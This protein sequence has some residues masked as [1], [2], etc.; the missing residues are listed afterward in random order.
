M[1]Q[2][3]PIR[4]LHLTRLFEAV[5]DGG[6]GGG[7]ANALHGGVEAF[8]VFGLVDGVAAGADEFHAMLL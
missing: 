4:P 2:G 3:K 5:G 6:A 7:Q 8:A 1:M